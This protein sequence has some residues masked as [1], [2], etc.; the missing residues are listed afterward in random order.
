[1]LLRIKW[2]IEEFKIAPVSARIFVDEGFK[3][4]GKA[5]QVPQFSTVFT[6]GPICFAKSRSVLPIQL[7]DFAAYCL[8]K[9][10]ILLAKSDLT[11]RDKTL[12]EILSG[13]SWNY[14][15]IEKKEISL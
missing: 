8:N 15:N 4:S 5:I 1:M 10:Q 7:A 13:T 2:Y 9:T 11:E 3:R 6:D 12:L 14:Q